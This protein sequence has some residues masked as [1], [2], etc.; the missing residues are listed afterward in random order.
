MLGL[1][2]ERRYGHHPFQPEYIRP[3]VKWH[4]VRKPGKD[5]ADRVFCAFLLLEDIKLA[6]QVGNRTKSREQA[7]WN[8][9]CVALLKGAGADVQ[10][11]Q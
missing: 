9:K 4:D 3:Y 1:P 10:A 5:L 2:E 11:D 8:A 6:V 7:I